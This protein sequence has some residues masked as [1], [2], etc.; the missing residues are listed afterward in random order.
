MTQGANE[1][2]ARGEIEIKG[3][4]KSQRRRLPLSAVIASRG[5]ARDARRNF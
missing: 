1:V 3:K 2:T 4:A 5:R